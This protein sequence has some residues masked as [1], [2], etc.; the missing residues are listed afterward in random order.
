MSF[1]L[2]I[3]VMRKDSLPE[4]L[5]YYDSAPSSLVSR[6]LVIDFDWCHTQ[7]QIQGICLSD[8]VEIY[9]RAEEYFN[10]SRA[11]NF[12]V[13]LSNST[14]VLVCDADVRVSLET[15]TFLASQVQNNS[16]FALKEV[17]ESSDGSRRRGLGI[18]ALSTSDF[19]KIHGHNGEFEGWGYEDVD[20]IRRLKTNG[21]AVEE[22]GYGTHLSHSDHERTRNYATTNKLASKKLN[23]E[24]MRRNILSNSN[25]GTFDNDASLAFKR[26]L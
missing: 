24:I 2:I 3:P 22:V 14:R 21:I 25:L 8:K 18:I 11:I 1:D 7:V 4:I 10:K 6:V 20:F 9:S 26:K 5:L 13:S 12:G 23:Q 15:L 17:I 19:K 16:A